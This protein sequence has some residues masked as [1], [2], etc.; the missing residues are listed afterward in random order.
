MYR[1]RRGPGAI[2]SLGVLVSID[3]DD[4]DGTAGDVSKRG[5]GTVEARRCTACGSNHSLQGKSEFI[6]LLSTTQRRSGGARKVRGVGW[7]Q[8]EPVNWC[9]GHLSPLA[10]FVVECAEYVI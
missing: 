4:D 1:H 10:I 7:C 5:L 9:R 6:V 3:V 2:E 8:A